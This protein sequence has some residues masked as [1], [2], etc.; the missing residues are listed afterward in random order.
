MEAE[1]IVALMIP[2]T[3]LAMVG[4][5]A[6]GTGRPWPAIRLWRTKGAAFLAMVLALNALLPALL[7]PSIAAHHL[8]DVASLGLVPSVVIGF[9]MLSLGNALLHR[10]YHRF[11]PLWRWVHQLHHA[12]QRLDIPG[13]AVFTPW[14][15]TLNIAMFQLVIVFLLG[16]DPLAAAIVG[17]IAVFYGMFQHFNIRTPQWL[18]FVIQRPESHGVHHRRGFHASNYSD[19]PLWDMLWGTFRNPKEYRGEVGFEGNDATRMAPMFVGRDANIEAY[20]PRNRGRVETA[21]N[22]A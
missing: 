5:E 21:G 7:P 8:F 17:Y 19:L 6:L 3:W 9:L 16:L 14:E 11:D 13:A 10:A 18:G 1:A 12:P 15:V 20:G 2:L 4:I 22:P